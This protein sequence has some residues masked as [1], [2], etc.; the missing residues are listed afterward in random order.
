MRCVLEDP[1]IYNP[2]QTFL[3][4]DC[5]IHIFLSFVGSLLKQCN[6]LGIFLQFSLPPPYTKLKLGKK[7]LDTRVQHCLFFVRE[8]LDL[9]ELENA[10]ETQKFPKTCVHD[11]S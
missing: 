6:L 7:I 11:C 3:R 9:F 1:I 4:K 2:G 5:N 10:P 8:G